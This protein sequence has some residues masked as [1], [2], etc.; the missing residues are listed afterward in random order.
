MARFPSAWLVCVIALATAAT[1]AWGAGAHQ[2][3]AAKIATS[4]QFLDPAGWTTTDATGT[5]YVFRRTTFEPK[6]YPS[7]YRGTFPGY[8]YGST[9]RFTVSVANTAAMGAKPLRV[10]VQAVSSVLETDGS[11]GQQLGDTQ[12]WIIDGLAPGQSTTLAGSVTIVGDDIPS[13]LDLTRI[14]IR[15][16]NNGSADAALIATADAV[17]CPPPA[18]AAND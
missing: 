5:T 6:I 4:V 14:R 16:L 7:L 3:E 9:M 12:E 17:W 10:S 8:Y 11:L 1:S 13:G 18:E 15:H 2:G